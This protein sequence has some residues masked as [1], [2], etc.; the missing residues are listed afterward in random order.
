LLNESLDFLPWNGKSLS[1]NLER[2][3]SCERTTQAILGVSR[4]E[5]EAL[6][7]GMEQG[8]VE[9]LAAK[10][11]RVRHVGAGPKGKLHNGRLK[12][13]FILFYLKVYPTFDLISVFFEI[14]RGQCC[15]WM[16]ALRPILEK[17]LRRRLVL[18]QRRISSVAGFFQQFPGVS[19]VLVDA[20]ERPMQRPGKASTNRK[21]YSG[22]RKRHTRKTVVV[23][24]TKRRILVLT[25]SKRGSRH[26]KRLADQRRV[27]ETIPPQVSVIT[28]TG[29]QGAKHLGLCQPVK[30]S[31]RKPLT[32][33]DRA[34]N[35]LVSSIRVAVEHAIGGMKRFGAVSGIYRNRKA[36]C[37]DSF[38][39]LG[40]G[41]WNF[42]L[43]GQA[44]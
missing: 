25:S 20:T 15:R 1:M 39:L 16:H 5:F 42:R 35:G 23:S 7:P 3:L 9:H 8:Y 43:S 38:N 17:Q 33:A 6:A 41:L 27:F 12:L 14:D 21:H 10:P 11:D 4:S 32:A 19:E 30:S 40:A 13:L 37:D 34:W 29:F 18:P 24:D 26:D 22:K 44:T 2:I 31:K 36:C 28:D